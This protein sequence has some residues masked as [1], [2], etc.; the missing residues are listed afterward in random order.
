MDADSRRD[1]ET[2]IR[3]SVRAREKGEYHLEHHGAEI[4]RLAAQH[5][6]FLDF[7][8]TLVVAHID[9][10][11][12]NLR[13]LDSG[14]ADGRTIMTASRVFMINVPESIRV[15][16]TD[17]TI[18]T[19]R[20]LSDLR[21][22]LVSKGNEYIGTDSVAKFFGETAAPDLKLVVQ[23]IDDPWPQD[24]SSSFDYVHQRLVIPGCET[25]PASTAIKHLCD[26]VKPG[27]WIELIEQD[28]N[29]PNPGAFAKA[30][31]VLR[32]IFTVAGSGYDYPLK[33]KGWLEDAGIEDVHQEIF[34]VPVGAKNP[35]PDLARKSTWQI[36]SALS[37]FLPMAKGLCWLY[38]LHHTDLLILCDK[39]FHFRFLKKNYRTFRLIQSER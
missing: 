17:Q 1:S 16:Y 23:R 37:G 20:W 10:E 24:W 26:L 25:I 4:A 21:S 32:E 31:G 5:E 18:E 8:K 29:Q 12:P 30:E 36:C 22:S 33:M 3:A 15:P 39:L 7:M 19:G 28:H 6:V 9:L 13:I 2:T 11:Q 14:T 27:G 38:T 34:D 35:N